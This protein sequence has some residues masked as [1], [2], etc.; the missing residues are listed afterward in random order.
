MS[1]ETPVFNL[2][3]TYVHLRDG[4]QSDPV[5]LTDTF[6]PEVMAGKCP[7][8][9]SG[10]LVLM[11][12][13]SEDWPTWEMHPAGDE[14]VYVLS[15]AMDLMLDDGE[16]PSTVSLESGSGCLVPCGVWHTARVSEPC[17]ALFITAGAGTQTRPAG[18]S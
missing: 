12:K 2:S 16:E 8:L 3:T 10:R 15:G 4:G 9:F 7:E 6:W 5:E 1:A 13:F 18:D 14:L 11:M 17:E